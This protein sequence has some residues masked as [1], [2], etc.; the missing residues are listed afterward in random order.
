MTAPKCIG[1]LLLIVNRR[2][3]DWYKTQKTAAVV[4]DL[5][6]H[7][8]QHLKRLLPLLHSPLPLQV[9]GCMHAWVKSRE[10][11]QLQCT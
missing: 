7:D 5:P 3:P 4:Q 11:H 1:H 8:L 9:L 6:I 2:I 10:A